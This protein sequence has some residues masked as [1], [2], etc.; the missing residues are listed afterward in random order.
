MKRLRWLLTIIPCLYS[1][2]IP[3]KMKLLQ[4][5]EWFHL[6]SLWWLWMV[7]WLILKILIFTCM[8]YHTSWMP[9]FLIILLFVSACLAT[10][11]LAIFL[12][13]NQCAFKHLPS[14]FPH[15]P[16]KTMLRLMHYHNND[17]SNL[18]MKEENWKMLIIFSLLKGNS[19][20]T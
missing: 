13:S 17:N 3:S 12:E 4:I 7:L 20:A 9:L 2:R 8:F 16:L 6:A 10:S 1:L 11:T 19:N 14:D 15:F 18:I 5:S